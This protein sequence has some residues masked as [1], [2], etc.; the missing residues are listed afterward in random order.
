ML[1][2]SECLLSR[3]RSS[4]SR[5]VLILDVSHSKGSPD[6]TRIQHKRL[7]LVLLMLFLNQRH[8]RS[9]LVFK[10]ALSLLQIV[11]QLYGGYLLYI[12]CVSVSHP[13]VLL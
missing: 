6:H 12:L 5:Y 11:G 4:D 1:L 8:L 3:F 10:D 13:L 9:L 7:R 2:K